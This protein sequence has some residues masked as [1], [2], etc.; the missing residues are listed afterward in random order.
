ME[1]SLVSHT[2]IIKYQ[3]WCLVES[4]SP[5]FQEGVRDVENRRWDFGGDIFY[6]GSGCL[7]LGCSPVSMSSIYSHCYLQRSVSTQLGRRLSRSSRA[8][9]V[10]DL[11]HRVLSC[12]T[13]VCPEAVAARCEHHLHVVVL[14]LALP[15]LAD[16]QH[17]PHLHCSC[18]LSV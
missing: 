9:V 6:A 4:I 10:S 7:Q 13:P 15:Q 16:A 1:K 3:E 5:W 14:V 12:Q 2:G 11:R 18:R 8:S 17:R